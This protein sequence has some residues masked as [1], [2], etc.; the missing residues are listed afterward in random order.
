MFV[1]IIFVR[2]QYYYRFVKIIF[3]TYFFVLPP[4]EACPCNVSWCEDLLCVRIKEFKS[5]SGVVAWLPQRLKS[6]FFEKNFFTPGLLR[7]PSTWKKF[8]KT[9]IL[10][11]EANIALSYQNGYFFRALSHCGALWPTRVTTHLTRFLFQISSLDG[12][13][14]IFL[15]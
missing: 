4:R 11:F 2:V 10:A 9:L 14:I 13:N 6:T 1:F 5:V 3:R 8:Q 12:V 7:G 15:R